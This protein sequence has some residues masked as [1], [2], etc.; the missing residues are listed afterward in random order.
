MKHHLDMQ[1]VDLIVLPVSPT[2]K[3]LPLS[4]NPALRKHGQAIPILWTSAYSQRDMST[5]TSTFVLAVP[6]TDLELAVYVVCL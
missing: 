6:V 3:L 4:L 2:L 5:R 1:C